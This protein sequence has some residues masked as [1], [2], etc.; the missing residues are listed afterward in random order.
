MAEFLQQCGSW[1][2]LATLAAY[3]AGV[4]VNRKTGKALFNPLL[5]G[6][7]FMIVFLSCFGVPYADYKSSA[8]PVSWLLMPATVSLAIP[9]YEKWELLEKNLAAI[10]ASIAAGVLTSLG[11]VLAMAWVL[12]LERVAIFA[13]RFKQAGIFQRA[14]HKRRAQGVHRRTAEEYGQNRKQRIPHR[15]V[16]RLCLQQ[17]VP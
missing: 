11:S 8:Q 6:S 4:W 13:Q 10:F 17:A 3:A 5:M 2:V 16:V 9:L 15:P 14:H 1:G 7:I 12:K